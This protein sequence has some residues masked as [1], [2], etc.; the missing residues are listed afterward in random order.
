MRHK[1]PKNPDDTWLQHQFS[2]K[3]AFGSMDTWVCGILGLKFRLKIAPRSSRLVLGL[4]SHGST[5]L[6]MGSLWR[7]FPVQREWKLVTSYSGPYVPTLWRHF[8]AWR[9][10]KLWVQRAPESW[11]CFGDTFPVEGNRNTVAWTCLQLKRVT[12][13]T[14]SRWKGIET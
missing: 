8:P 3:I 7:H 6:K 2:Q 9:E 11:A 10:S 5:G 12:L 13:D 1:L 14:L 4:R